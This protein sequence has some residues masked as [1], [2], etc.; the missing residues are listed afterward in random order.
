MTEDADARMTAAPAPARAEAAREARDEILH[1]AAEV[2]M[3]FGF[4]AT[5]IDDIA[6]R[7]GATEGG[8]YHH[9]KSNSIVERSCFKPC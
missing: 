2:F 3:E 8:I 1:A 6:E 4:A 7:L 9:F 5:T